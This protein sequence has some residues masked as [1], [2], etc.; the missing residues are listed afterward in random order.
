[1][2]GLKETECVLQA[3]ES[4]KSELIRIVVNSVKIPSVTPTPMSGVVFR[5]PFGWPPFETP[6]DAGIC[7]AAAVAREAALNEP[8]VFQRA[9]YTSDASFLSQ[10]GIPTIVMGPG[11]I[12]VAHGVNE[13]VEIQDIVDAAKIY[14]LTIAEWC[15]VESAA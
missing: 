15:G 4:L 6:I 14:A 5:T 3:I 8:P 12:E 7:K 2:I 10:A 9:T 1:M 11:S 13:Y